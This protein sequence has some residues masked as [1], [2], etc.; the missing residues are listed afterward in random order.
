MAHMRLPFRLAWRPGLYLPLLAAAAYLLWL[1][2][3]PPTV[4]RGLV[5]ILGSLAAR[6]AAALALLA[7]SRRLQHSTTQQAWRTFGV[8]AAL[9]AL[10][11]AIAVVTRATHAGLLPLPSLTDWIGVA[12][13]LAALTGIAAHHQRTPERFSRI[14]E[15]LDVAILALAVAA[16]AWLLFIRSAIAVGLGTP[17]QVLWAAL[18]PAIDLV[19]AGLLARLLL[20]SADTHGITRYG[21]LALAAL[22]LAAADIG[23]GYRRLLG[24]PATGGFIEAGWMT[25]G[26]LMV[27]AAQRLQPA[28]AQR[29]EQQPT[30]LRFGGRIEALLPIGFT[31][32]VVGTVIIEWGLSRQVDWL[33]IV[34]AVALSL[35]LMVR[36]GLIIGQMEMRQYAALINSSAD[37]SFICDEQGKFLLSN[38]AFQRALGWADATPRTSRLQDVLA[39]PESTEDIIEKGLRHGWA[40]EVTLLRRDPHGPTLPAHLSLRPIQDERR[41]LPVLAGTAHDL[42]LIKRRE[43]ELRNA[44]DEVAAARSDLQR[45]NAAL[46]E[47]V[48]ER[49]RQ[50]ELTIADLARLNEE[51]Q[52]LDRLK[53]EFVALVSHELRAPLTNIRGGIELIL[54]RQ[55]PLG[56]DTQ[57]TLRLVQQESGR[58]ATL[59][60]AILDLSALEAGRFPLQLRPVGLADV[61]QEVLAQF[62]DLSRLC[63]E[64]P[65]DLPKVKADERGLKS[66]LY[67]LLDNAIKYAPEGE[68][69]LEASPEDG[70]IQMRLTDSGPGIPLEERERVFEMFHR[71]D[72]RDKR[73]VY[74]HGLGLPMAR[75]LVEAMGGG[76]RI[77]AGPR[78]GTRVVFWLPQADA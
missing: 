55:M 40:G 72:S 1:L 9:W 26:L 3:T 74:G 16:L 7:E 69:V 60:E 31:Y 46:E 75:R 59:V 77:E 20:R 49:T 50:L 66:I 13:A 24:D 19:L 51:L 15:A 34:A 25:A 35:L 2:A 58:L 33:M 39:A 42:R 29:P 48:D 44:L 53:S 45:L 10:A 71:L 67:H 27:F 47:K 6:S 65:T 63:T 64:I 52:E 68:L 37:L 23:E 56:S 21:L 61:T 73:E 62:P 78:H 38:P 18:P 36:Q 22:S 57:D 14:R 32:A 5:A 76:I 17:I 12:G 54:E 11:A 8:G 4:S 70:N 41:S 30:L 43:A 28:P